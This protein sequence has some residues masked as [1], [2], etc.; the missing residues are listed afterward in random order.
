[1]QSSTN[2]LALSWY[3]NDANISY[4]ISTNLP[5]HMKVMFLLFAGNVRKPKML[6]IY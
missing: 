6:V 3:N 4:H 2:T 1:M 5:I